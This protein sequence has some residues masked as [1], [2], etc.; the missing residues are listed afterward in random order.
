M[1]EK[2]INY[3]CNE[4]IKCKIIKGKLHTYVDYRNNELGKIKFFEVDDGNLKEITNKE[5]LKQAVEKNY[6]IKENI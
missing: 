1:I 5:D 4:F 2:K 3:E 6:I